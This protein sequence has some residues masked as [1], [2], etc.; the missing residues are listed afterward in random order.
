PWRRL[1]CAAVE[2]R[3]DVCHQAVGLRLLRAAIDGA[4]RRWQRPAERYGDAAGPW[5]ALPARERLE[6]A[7]DGDG[8]DRRLRRGRDVYDAG[9]RVLRPPGARDPPFGKDDQRLTTGEHGTGETDSLRI[10]APGSHR[11]RT[12]EAQPGTEPRMVPVGAIDQEAHLPAQEVGDEGPV[13]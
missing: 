7:A 11:H 13:E 8:H 4:G 6:G 3:R 5:Q 2:Q 9:L 1:R 12:V 10:G